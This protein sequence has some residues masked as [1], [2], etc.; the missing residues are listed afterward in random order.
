[1]IWYV[2]IQQIYC[3]HRYAIVVLVMR[4]IDVKHHCCD[5]LQES[6]CNVLQYRGL[7]FIVK[8]NFGLS[9]FACSRVLRH[10]HMCF[11]FGYLCFGQSH[12]IIRF[13]LGHSCFGHGHLCFGHGHL[14]FGHGYMFWAWAF[15]FWAW[16]HVLGLVTYVLSMDIYGHLCFGHGHLCFVFSVACIVCCVSVAG[17][18]ERVLSHRD[19]RNR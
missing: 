6:T 8:C 12:K 7:G 17:A 3:Q 13:G 10:V 16:T 18:V 14:C 11:G 15:M 1:M 9:V 4:D 19:I 5:I 2:F